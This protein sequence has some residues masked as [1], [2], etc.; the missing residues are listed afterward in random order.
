[1]KEIKKIVFIFLIWRAFLFLPLFFGQ[2]IPYRP[3]YEYTNIFT[4]T[5]KYFPVD[6]PLL[7]PWANFDGV[8]Y[9]DIA[10]NGYKDNG[11][12]FPFFP[13]LI[14]F[15]AGVF[16]S[17]Q[18]FGSQQ[19]FSALIISNMSFLLSLVLLY[20][21][22]K[23]DYKNDVAF[24]TVVFLIFFPTSFFFTTVYTESLFLLLSVLIFYL[25]RK[26]LWLLAGLFG[27]FLT[28]TRSIGLLILPVLIYEYLKQNKLSKKS[29]FFILY[30]LFMIPIGL[31]AFSYYCNIKWHDPLYFLHAQALF[32]NGRSAGFI[33]PLQTV[34]RYIKIMFTVSPKIYE[35][36][37]ALLEFGSFWFA[38]FGLFIAWRK[39]V[40]LSYVLFSALCFL[41][42]ISSGTFTGLPRYI[43][44]LFPI[45]VGIALFT[46]NKY[47]K[48]FYILIGLTL[49]FVFLMFFSRG[50]YIA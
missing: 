16:G 42:P 49:Q 39:K 41:V 26:K 1:M 31:I 28:I 15:V 13:I 43:I 7:N 32:K 37:I 45:F 40:N 14:R 21:L 23:L 17:G 50:Y 4:S 3:R 18:A 8:H 12:F 30:F 24:T 11:G 9:L 20:K 2:N 48:I 29:L 46:K 38:C 10:G 5:L 27:M 6:S 22:I 19:F 36:W 44:I 35:F 33:F 47:V 25:A 34:Y